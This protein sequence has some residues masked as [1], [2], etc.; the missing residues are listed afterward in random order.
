M[1]EATLLAY[2]AHHFASL[3]K[4]KGWLSGEYVLFG[5]Y[6][7]CSQFLYEA[8]AVLGYKFRD[9]IITFVALFC[10]QG[11]ESD[12]VAHL[13]DSVA[14]ELAQLEREP[15]DFMDLY[16]KPEAT[17][18]IRVMRDAGLTTFSDWTDFPKLAKQKM[19]VVDVFS[20]LQ[21]TA[22]EGVG[23]G[24]HFPV[25]TEK[26]F[27]HEVDPRLWS[28]FRSHGLNIPASPPKTKSVREREAE[29]LLLIKPYVMKARPDLL[30]PL[31]L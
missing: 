25:L 2:L 5:D 26:L 11:R 29:A 28:K 13:R 4:R 30:G 6:M 15:D 23:L 7:P 20:Q 9:Q 1:P 22:A 14:A 31:R 3:I 10:E 12:L 18:L 17:R 19:R 8:S 24:S 27:A 16:F 21:F